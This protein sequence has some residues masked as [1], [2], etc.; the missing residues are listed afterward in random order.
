MEV[1]ISGVRSENRKNN[2]GSI[3]RNV[4]KSRFKN[5]IRITVFSGKNLK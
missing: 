5:Y 1:I 4:R 3:R 2:Y